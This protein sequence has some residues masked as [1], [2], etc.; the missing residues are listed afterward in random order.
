MTKRTEKG[1]RLGPITPPELRH[2]GPYVVSREALQIAG[3]DGFFYTQPSLVFSHPVEGKINVYIGKQLRRQRIAI[4]RW[5]LDTPHVKWSVMALPERS[6]SNG[7]TQSQNDQEM[8]I[9]NLSESSCIDP[10][11]IDSELGLVNSAVLN[12]ARRV[13]AKP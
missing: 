6:S 7:D 12:H 11:P 8:I 4:V 5:A 10:A 13:H 3:F 9:R 2:F 1:S